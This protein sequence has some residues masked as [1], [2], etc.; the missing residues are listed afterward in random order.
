VED[1]PSFAVDDQGSI[2]RRMYLSLEE[3][4]FPKKLS[5]VFCGFGDVPTD[6]G[7]VSALS[8]GVEDRNDVD[9]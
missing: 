4:G 2:R 6:A 7:E 5:F 3:G 9:F 1:L 8:S